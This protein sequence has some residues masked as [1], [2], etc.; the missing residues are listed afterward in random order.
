MVAEK[1][2]FNDP[3]I[4]AVK[5]ETLLLYGSYSDCLD[6]GKE[7]NEKIKDSQLIAVNGDH[8]IPIQE[9]ALIGN[10]INTFF[11]N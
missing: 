10:T 9:P 7:L 3:A 6:T 2:F 11:M 1:D 5:K 4:L 8:N